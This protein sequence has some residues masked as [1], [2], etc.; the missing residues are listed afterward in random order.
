MNIHIYH[1]H[2]VLIVNNVDFALIQY[3][4][5]NLAPISL[6]GFILIKDA[7]ISK[8]NVEGVIFAKKVKFGKSKIR[9]DIQRINQCKNIFDSIFK[10]IS[11]DPRSMVSP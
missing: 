10:T 2:Y 3:F 11:D 5:Y 8:T 1:R 7:L 9:M 4:I 6:A